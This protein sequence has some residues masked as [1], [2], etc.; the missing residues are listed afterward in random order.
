MSEAPR[1]SLIRWLLFALGLALLPHFAHLVSW[2][3]LLALG[4]GLWRYRLA[5][6]RRP[7]P[8]TWLLL[9]L[10]L[11]VAAGILV[12]YGGLFGRDAGV[13]LLVLM[14]A[15]KTLEAKSRRDFTL[16]VYLGY[17]LCIC[18]FLF[19]QS[20]PLAAYMPLP[21]LAL[22]ATLV[23]INHT[24]GA[25]EGVLR[26]RLAGAMLLQA[27]PVML[28][29]FVLFPRV[30]GPL[31]GIP[32]DTAR[33]VTG[34]SDD[35]SPGSIS[36]LSRSDAVAFRAIFRG[37]PPP[38]ATLYW[39]GPVLWNFDGR[40]WRA[41]ERPIPLPGPAYQAEG[42]PVEYTVTLE[43]H[44]KPWLFLL[45]LPAKVPGIGVLTTDYQALAR[46]P[47]RQ[48]LRYEAASHLEYREASR[49]DA[50][51][52]ARALQLP[53]YG[54][55]RARQLAERWRAENGDPLAIIRQALALYNAE[56]TYTLTPPPLG[57]SPVDGFLFDTRK[58]FCEHFAGSFVFLM[59]AAGIPARVVTGYQGGQ[60]NPLGDYLIVRQSDAHAWAEV[61]LEERGWM[62]IDPTA[63][64]APQRVELG[65][66][67]ALPA[68]EPLP[69]LARME[70]TWLKR[71]E[72]GWD[73]V[74]NGWNQWV[75]GY[76]QQR[77]MEFLAR[78]SGSRPEWGDMALWLTGLLTLV[79]GAS[80]ALLLRP[81]WP[82]QDPAQR[83]WRR[84]QNRLAR[85][86][87]PPRPAE[88][89][90]DFT[91]RAARQLPRSQQQIRQIGTLYLQLRYGGL[92]D[93]DGI[94]RLQRLVR[95]FHPR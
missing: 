84:F 65:V 49:L 61:W 41:G 81:G 31:W 43:P 28:A 75:L 90:R 59:R 53:P 46:Q 77:Q 94:A 17:F 57:A 10:T 2:V 70:M 62:R 23:G 26:F 74:N 25:L 32:Q 15:L 67:A 21:L 3:P 79:V 6:T 4:L 83:A 35:M 95:Q 29:L 85:A 9:P 55:P 8:G 51:T 92:P 16:T 47:V 22:T 54:N 63:A 82:A 80:A 14:T 52:R 58:G 44:H 37:A 89:P 12:S 39:R 42:P 91:E 87:M 76:N 30:P 1:L 33:G 64:V 38:S 45:D 11:A 50:H 36:A 93:H 66:A 71:L 78:L 56:F 7:L 72:L 24:D 18:A 5:A 86:G 13:A 40:T 48:R 60:A 73:A 69:A 27:V 68:G 88:G 34:L 20:I 19:S